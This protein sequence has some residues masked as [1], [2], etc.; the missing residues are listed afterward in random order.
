MDFNA[1]LVEGLFYE[2]DG[3]LF[4]EDDKGEHV[5]VADVLA[6][7][8][9]QRVQFAVH[10]LPPNGIEPDKPGAGS[11]QWPGGVG[12]P[13]GHEVTPDRLVSFHLEGVLK[14]DPWRVELFD[15]SRVPVPFA[16]MPGH[17]GRLG[18]ATVVDVSKMRDILSGLDVE[19]MGTQDL[20]KVLERLK[21]AM[22]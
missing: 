5:A 19:K 15:G 1:I 13:A 9:D 8:V 22:E 12:C 11:C 18:A 14:V 21:K 16:Q 4:I 10:H 6:P 7:V 20:E 2:K 3:S 17:Y